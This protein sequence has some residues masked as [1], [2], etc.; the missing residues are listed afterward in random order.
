MTKHT[1]WP[2]FDFDDQHFKVQRRDLVKKSKVKKKRRIE[3]VRLLNERK[4]RGVKEKQFQLSEVN[5]T[6]KVKSLTFE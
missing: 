4:V 5:E 1:S 6:E 2:I 3:Q